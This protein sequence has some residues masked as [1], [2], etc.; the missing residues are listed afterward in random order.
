MKITFPMSYKM[1]FHCEWLRIFPRPGSHA[2][3]QNLY[4][5]KSKLLLCFNNVF[6]LPLRISSTH[7]D[8]NWG[9]RKVFEGLHDPQ[10]FF[11]RVGFFQHVKSIC[12]SSSQGECV[13][14]ILS[15][16]GDPVF[17][18]CKEKFPLSEVASQDNLMRKQSKR[19]AIP[20]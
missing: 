13:A 5:T 6:R 1:T 4:I 10:L 16:Q 19:N 12:A 18:N 8:V 17:Q 9:I 11:G 14:V 15:T 20:L 7:K 2:S 3:I